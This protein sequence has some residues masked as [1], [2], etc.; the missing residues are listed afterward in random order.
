MENKNEPQKH[1]K[2]FQSS[3][4]YFSISVYAIITF[5]VCLMIF[6]FTNNWAHT[7]LQIKNLL[8]IFSPF[9]IAFLIA[10]FITPLVQYI[11]RK[12][13]EKAL[14]ERF[15]RFHLMISMILADIIMIGGIILI[16][17]FIVPQIITSISQLIRVSPTFYENIYTTLNTLDSRFPNLDLSFLYETVE[18]I[19]PDMFN[20]MSTFMSNTILPFLYNAGL[21]IISWFINILLAFVI[22]CYLLFSK[23]KLVNSLK[24]VIYAIF[25]EHIALLLF[26]TI[27]NCNTIFSQYITGKALDSMIIFFICLAAMLILKLPYALI[28]SLIVG[29]TNMIPYFGPFIGAIPGILILLI[30]S[31]KSSLIFALLIF[32]IQQIG[33][34]SCRERV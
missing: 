24:R 30:I 11:D 6:K 7:K 8:S 12:L 33:R 18:K 9:L 34:A 23:E 2:H 29:I 31:P 21:S 10:Y 13:F 17:I 20:S 15:K 1:K 27:Q 5:T 14:N 22:S 3:R 25:P 26:D 4:K 16:F 28:I 19:F 32:A